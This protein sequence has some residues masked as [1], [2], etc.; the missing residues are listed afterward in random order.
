LVTSGNNDPTGGSGPGSTQFSNRQTQGAPATVTRN[1]ADGALVIGL[2]AVQRV[3]PTEEA[4]QPFDFV[5]GPNQFLGFEQQGV[6]VLTAWMGFA[7]EE[8][9]LGART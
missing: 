5:I 4:W 7:L 2:T 1:V 6:G 9:T 8:T 3:A